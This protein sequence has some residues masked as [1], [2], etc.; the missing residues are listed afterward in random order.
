MARDEQ[1]YRGL[2]ARR[3]EQGLFRPLQEDWWSASPF[4]ALR[5]MQ[6]EMDRWFG[7]SG[8][9]GASEG[10][11][12]PGR[13]APHIDMWEENDQVMV[14]ADVPGVEPEDLELYCTD[15]TLIVRGESRTSDEREERGYHHRERRYG[16]FE[17]VLP[18]PAQV[19]REKIQ[20]SFKNGVLEVRMPCTENSRQRMQRI[21]IQGTGRF[22]TLAGAKGGET[23]GQAAS[24]MA[25]TGGAQMP[26]MTPP[27]GEGSD[28]QAGGDASPGTSKRGKR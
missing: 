8:L 7:R 24:E 19:D 12:S 23:T 21:P 27:Q 10:G 17:R 28:Q 26:G 13:W 25:S 6:E 11:Q 15:D 1:Q 16:R 9:M 22:S 20:A 18:L 5:R 14:R 3:G 4:T 2:P